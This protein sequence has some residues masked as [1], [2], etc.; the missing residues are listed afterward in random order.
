[1]PGGHLSS[2]GVP[3]VRWR[4]V[5]EPSALQAA[6]TKVKTHG[7]RY[8]AVS[9]INVITGQATLFVL[10]RLLTWWTD[11]PNDVSWTVANVLAVC[12]GAA[13]AYYLNRM[14]VWGKRGR[15]HLTREILPFWG[16]SL[17]G[18][19]LSTLAVSLAAN[20]TDV[21]IVANI[22]NI[23]AFGVLWVV[24]FFV[25]DSVVFGRGH[26]GPDGV[27]DTDDTAGAVGADGRSADPSTP[28]S[29]TP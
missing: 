25:L 11:W 6:F 5:S 19:I 17:A 23:L 26:H 10:V 29:L 3:T 1:M 4:L 21:K 14:W 2:V 24:K 27:D 7:L 13:P 18:L 22:A 15:S 9:V 12:I 16:F 20:L 8:S 28:T